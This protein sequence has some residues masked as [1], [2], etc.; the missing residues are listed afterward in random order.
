MALPREPAG[1][2]VAVLAIGRPKGG[3]SSPPRGGDMSEMMGGGAMEPDGDE[4]LPPGFESAASEAF[5][6]MDPANYGALKRLIAL[7]M[8]SGESY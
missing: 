1:E 7:C 6:D 2:D 5:P 4:G 3:A 8:E